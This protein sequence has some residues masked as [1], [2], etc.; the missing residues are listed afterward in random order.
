MSHY[1]NLLDKDKLI[2]TKNLK[3]IRDPFNGFKL[4]VKDNLSEEVYC[5]SEII[6]IFNCLLEN[7]NIWNNTS[8]NITDKKI[9]KLGSPIFGVPFEKAIKEVLKSR[10]IKS[11]FYLTNYDELQKQAVIA[12]LIVLLA[13]NK[14]ENKTELQIWQKMDKTEEVFYI[15]FIIDDETNEVE[16]LDG[17]TILFTLEQKNILFEKCK[18]IKG[19]NYQKHFKIN[20]SITFEQTINIIKKYFPIEELVEEYFEKEVINE[21]AI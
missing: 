6:P 5:A 10:F 8:L 18:K 1:Q 19:Y 7:K 14:K 13:K 16:H 15:H 17:A 4:F 3:I 2:H 11:R 9:R 12:D 20:S 21:I